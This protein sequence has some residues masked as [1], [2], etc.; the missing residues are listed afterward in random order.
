M[1][2]ALPRVQK[3]D[4][5]N[6]MPRSEV[7]CKG[8]PCLEKTWNTN[9]LASSGTSIVSTVGMKMSCLVSQSMITRMVLKPED[10]GSFSMKSM[11]ME[12]HRCSETGSYFRNS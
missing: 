12:F 3:K 1:S 2:R 5:T 4:N 7:T 6:S 8:T 9:S 10:R 11:E